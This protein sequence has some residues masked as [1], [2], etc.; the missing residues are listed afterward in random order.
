MTHLLAKYR[1]RRGTRRVSAL[2]LYAHYLRVNFKA[3][4]QYKGWP[5]QCLQ[6]L[7]IVVTDPIGVFLIFSRFGSVG[8]WSMERILLVYALA[9]TGF[10][11]A[12]LLARGYDYFPWKIRTGNFDRMLLRPRS[13]FVQ[14]LGSYFHL[15]R[16][17]R[18]VGGLAAIFWCLARLEIALT[19][20]RILL[21]LCALAGGLLAYTGVF[22]LTSG[23]AFYTIA[24]L[25][26]IFI[27]TNASY[28]VTRC[29]FPY[30]PT[31]LKGV[32]TFFMPMLV[33]SYYP[34]STLCG[35][36]EPAWLGWLALPAGLAFLLVSLG[37][38]RLGMRR[39]A[40]T[41]S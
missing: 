22:V 16:G 38:W 30:L 2:R 40:S 15:H 37:V 34:A 36:G 35:W 9:V 26:W 39:Y 10:G 8:A 18:V 3:G 13:T 31:W 19:L 24:A 21:L 6:V 14:V 17:A 33:V 27:L 20:P 25:D 11:L 23:I 1:A 29:P 32:F 41:G 7:F 12:E 5:L 4:L 28:Q